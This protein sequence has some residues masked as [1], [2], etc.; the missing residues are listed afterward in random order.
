MSV[1][2]FLVLYHSDAGPKKQ[3]EKYPRVSSEEGRASVDCLLPCL[4]ELTCEVLWTWS[5]LWKI[6]QLLKS[7]QKS[8]FRFFLCSLLSVSSFIGFCS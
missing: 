3:G 4:V 8:R 2:L 6:Y 7:F 1:C 5:F